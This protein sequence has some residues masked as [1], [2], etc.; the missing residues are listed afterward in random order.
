MSKLISKGGRLVRLSSGRLV[1]MPSFPMDEI[2]FDFFL[3]SKSA[4]WKSPDYFPEPFPGPYGRETAISG[5]SALLSTASWSGGGGGNNASA[6]SFWNPL[7]P[8]GFSYTQC[9]AGYACLL[10]D[11]SRYA[12][13]LATVRVVV[14]STASASGSGDRILGVSALA[15]LT[16]GLSADASMSVSSSGSKS[17][18]NFRL[19]DYLRVACWISG[20]AAPTNAYTYANGFPVV[21]I[22]ISYRV[23]ITIT[24]V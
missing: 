16:P 11:T 3:Y 17:F 4:A 14:A 7:T 13:F 5:V 20:N 10:R 22:Q 23:Y 1:R 19:S 12:G 6:S 15:G 24:G 2:Y 21:S 18:E 9:V 8:T